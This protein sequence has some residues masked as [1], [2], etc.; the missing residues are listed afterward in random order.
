VTM[1]MLAHVVGGGPV[2]PLWLTGTLLFGGAVAAMAVPQARRRACLAIAAVGLVATIAVYLL[3]PSAPTAPP[4]L[5]LSIAAPRDGAIVTSPVV[6][7][8]CA[9]SYSVPGAGRLLSISVDGSQVAEVN[10]SAAAINVDSG[11]H[12]VRVELVTSAHREYA[13]PVLTD[14]TLTVPGVGPLS[15]P[16][17]CRSATNLSP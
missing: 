6:M 8:V 9:G 17:D 14:E 12:I 5:S 1:P 13:P 16:P 2:W 11:E 10:T 15:Q 3:L 7:R 4:G